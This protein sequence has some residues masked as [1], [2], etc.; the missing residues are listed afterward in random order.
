MKG[1]GGASFIRRLSSVRCHLFNA[2]EV[3]GRSPGAPE[4]DHEP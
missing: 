1:E 4:P 3:K 2:W